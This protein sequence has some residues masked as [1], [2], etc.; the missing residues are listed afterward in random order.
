MTGELELGPSLGRLTDPPAPGGRGPLR[1]TLDD[2]RIVFVTELFDM[3]GAGRAAVRDGDRPAAVNALGRHRWLAAWDRASAGAAARITGLVNTGLR[4]AAEES[5]F[6]SGRLAGLTLTVDDTRAVA[7]RLGAGSA[8]LM[9]ALDAVD[10]PA[11][12]VAQG[13][14]SAWTEWIAAIGGVA[15]R[16]E[17]AWLSLESAAAREE[18][19]WAADIARVR[20]WR[21]PTWPL[22]VATA[23]VLAIA[24]YL[25][26]LLGGYL[27]VPGMFQ[28]FTR[29][30]WARM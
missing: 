12:L 1:L 24:T 28:G 8:D 15:R 4:S 19:D 16:V 14:D 27:R 10:E 2:L 30:W 11:A 18:H 26:L 23:L 7:A 13:S 5:R 17:S 21:R 22:W 25:G 29:F 3:A 6:P 9:S 20:A